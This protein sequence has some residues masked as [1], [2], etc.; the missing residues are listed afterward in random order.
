[1]PDAATIEKK[2]PAAAPA[3]PAATSAAAAVPGREDNVHAKPEAA[4]QEA[5]EKKASENASAPETAQANTESQKGSEQETG[6]S[7]SGEAG[8]DPFSELSLPEKSFLQQ[9]DLEEIKAFAKE[10]GL[11]LDQAKLLIER[12][13][14]AIAAYVGWQKEQLS[15]ERESS[16]IPSLKADKEL[17]GE[18]FQ[19]SEKAVKE[20]LSRFDTEGELQKALEATGLSQYPPLWRVLARAGRASARDKIVPGAG[21]DVGKRLVS[22]VEAFYGK[23]MKQATK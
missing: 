4:P 8:K 16:W 11:T 12:E 18:K 9:E 2:E 14:H 3:K 5:K 20:F 21:S 19:E 13:N 10:K 22:D 1:M 15:K 6:K 7:A 17:G 23:T